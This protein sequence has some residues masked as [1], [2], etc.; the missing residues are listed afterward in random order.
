MLVKPC[1]VPIA[2][3]SNLR[4]NS[5]PPRARLGESVAPFYHSTCLTGQPPTT[6]AGARQRFVQPTVRA[7]RAAPRSHG[8]QPWRP[9]PSL[10]T[11]RNR[12]YGDA[13]GLP[14]I[15]AQNFDG[16]TA[17][18]TVLTTALPDMYPI[19]YKRAGIRTATPGWGAAWRRLDRKS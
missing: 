2:E 8:F 5:P 18:A 16:H 13:T 10:A 4:I 15:A 11:V 6:A 1:S 7:K 14:H 9:R 12:G 17:A 19:G 3:P